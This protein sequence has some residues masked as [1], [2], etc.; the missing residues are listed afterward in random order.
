MRE[1]YTEGWDV[2]IRKRWGWGGGG[3]RMMAGD[4]IVDNAREIRK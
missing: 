3:L 2:C 1:K 4:K